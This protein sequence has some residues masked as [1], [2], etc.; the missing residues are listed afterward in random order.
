MDNS[1][2]DFRMPLAGDNVA[3]TEAELVVTLF[4]PLADF[5]FTRDDE[6]S[7][8]SDL[9]SYPVPQSSMS[10]LGLGLS[11]DSSMAGSQPKLIMDMG[12]QAAVPTPAGPEQ[13]SAADTEQ[14]SATPPPPSSATQF[15]VVTSLSPNQGQGLR[16]FCGITFQ[17]LPTPVPVRRPFP[18]SMLSTCSSCCSC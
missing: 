4:P 2:W 17:H 11:S 9:M 1:V 7:L 14:V 10:G 6:Q 12:A 16:S 18:T 13:Q 8:L 3:E 5:F 15:D